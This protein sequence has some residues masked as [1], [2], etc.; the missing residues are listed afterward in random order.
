MHRAFD[1]STLGWVGFIIVAFSALW[2]LVTIEEGFNRI[3][4]APKGRSWLRRLMIYWFL[5]TFPAVL[6]G[7][8]PFLTGLFDAF[9]SSCFRNGHGSPPASASSPAR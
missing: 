8:V 7:A 3:Y 9:E 6:I 4:R 2:V 5:L 1:L